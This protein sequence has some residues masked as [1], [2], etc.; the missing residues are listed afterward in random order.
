MHRTMHSTCALFTKKQK[1]SCT[2]RYRPYNIRH[3][4]P[5]QSQEE[6]VSLDCV[7]IDIYFNILTI[8]I[9]DQVVKIFSLFRCMLRYCSLN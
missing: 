2:Q 5:Y 7:V 4:A 6:I 8:D 9:Y 1:G 3:E